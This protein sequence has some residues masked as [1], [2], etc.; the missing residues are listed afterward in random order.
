MLIDEI[1]GDR[2]RPV[3]SRLPILIA[4]IAILALS[5]SAPASSESRKLVVVLY[6]AE[7]DGAPGIVL[8][9]RAI[10][11]TFASESPA[12]IDIRN[13]YLDTSRFRDA[14]FMQTQVSLLQQKY[15]G[16]KVDLVIAGLSSGLDFT[17]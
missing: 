4:L 1:P 7:S 9:N 3:F 5:S 6:P 10:R 2:S 11:S 15:A 14:E 13:E 12:P 8:V 16:R 17:L